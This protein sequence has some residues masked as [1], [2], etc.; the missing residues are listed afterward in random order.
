MNPGVSKTHSEQDTMDL[1][2]TFAQTCRGDETFLLVGPLGSGKTTF[3]RGF[4]AGLH[5]DVNLVSS[6]SF[7]IIQNYKAKF[8]VWHVDLYRLN[9]LPELQ[10]SGV[11]DLFDEP[12]VRVIEWAERLAGY[13]V[14]N[15]ILLVFRDLGDDNRE[16]TRY[17][18]KNLLRGW[19]LTDL[20]N[21][22]L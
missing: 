6:P 19:T 21:D 5:G 15:A 20:T 3:V 11:L 2:M 1:G 18:Q 16:I 8:P 22:L 4:V 17:P 7:V 12:G 14:C 9:S 13:P 10:G